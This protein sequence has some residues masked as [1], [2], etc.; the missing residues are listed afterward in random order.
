[1]FVHRLLSRSACVPLLAAC[2][3]TCV[4]WAGSYRSIATLTLPVSA[5]GTRWELTSYRGLLSFAMIDNYP[6]PR[7][8]AANAFHP[9]SATASLWDDI[10]WA[11]SYAGFSGS[12]GQIWLVDADD[13][14]VNRCWSSVIFPYWMIFGFT[15]LAPLW[16]SCLLIRR[17][18]WATRDQCADCGYEL[19]GGAAC[20]ACAARA[21]LIGAGPRVQ[22]VHSV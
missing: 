7:Q 17:R 8:F 11:D 14:P 4:L 19:G 21:V 10:N 18:R 9:D 1:M 3:I 12:D 6:T 15:A 20:R 16:Q 22:P 13:E 2:V 5:G